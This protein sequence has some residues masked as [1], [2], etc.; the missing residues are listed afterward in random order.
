[1]L[2]FLIDLSRPVVDVQRATSFLTTFTRWY[3]ASVIMLKGI[4][5]AL[6]DSTI[7]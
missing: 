5:G 6:L 7:H 4:V 2:D 1:M 3:L